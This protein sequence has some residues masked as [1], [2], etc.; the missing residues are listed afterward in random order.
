MAFF[1]HF[2]DIFF[3]YGFDRTKKRYYNV[4]NGKEWYALKGMFH[5]SHN[6]FEEPIE[7]EDGRLAQLGRL[8][9]KSDTQIKEHLHTD[10]FELTV[11]TDGKGIITTNG[12]EIPCKKGDIYLS[13]PYDSHKITSDRCDPLKFDF[14]AFTL[15][16]ELF[17]DSFDRIVG[18]FHSSN[19]RIIHDERI[20]QAVSEVLSS[21]AALH[22]QG[23]IPC[24]R[25]ADRV[26]A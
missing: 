15:K 9:C 6:Y 8:Y 1:M 20:S 19:K 10:L 12:Y 2:Y 17:A 23:Y 26:W 14:Y 18:E 5:L 13:L 16:N 22:P 3:E 21:P 4:L 7:L 24:T 11:V 25:S